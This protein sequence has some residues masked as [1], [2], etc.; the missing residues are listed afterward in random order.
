MNFNE[1]CERRECGTCEFGYTES[2]SEC[3]KQF[4]LNKNRFK[5]KIDQ[6]QMAMLIAD[7][8][9]GEFTNCTCECENCP[10]NDELPIKLVGK[11]KITICNMITEM[12]YLFN[13][14]QND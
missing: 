9:H 2:L 6:D 11:K 5:N 8:E 7:W 10:L 3:V 4:E 1:F 14:V 12:S 13:E